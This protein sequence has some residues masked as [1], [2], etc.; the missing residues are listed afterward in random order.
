MHSRR[1]DHARYRIMGFAQV[2]ISIDMEDENIESFG[3]SQHRCH[4]AI[5]TSSSNKITMIGLRKVEFITD[6]LIEAL[7]ACAGQ[8]MLDPF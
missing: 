1:K 3:F 8:S 4:A 6:V 2:I 5:V 7:V